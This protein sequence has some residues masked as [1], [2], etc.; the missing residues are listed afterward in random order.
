MKNKRMFLSLAF[1]VVCLLFIT[2]AGT[3]CF[4]ELGQNIGSKL[5]AEITAQRVSVHQVVTQQKILTQMQMITPQQN[6]LQQLIMP[7]IIIRMA[8]LLEMRYS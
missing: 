4:Y 8:A 3:G 5:K 2:T 7:M 1:L 6:F